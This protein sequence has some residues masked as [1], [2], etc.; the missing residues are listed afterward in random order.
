[1]HT[2]SIEGYWLAATA[3]MTGT[4]WIPYIVNRMVERGIFKALWDPR[5]DTT[6]V[7]QWADRMMRAHKNAVENLC[8]FAPL[9]LLAIVAGKL[10]SMTAM[11][12]EVYFFARLAHFIVYSAG[13]PIVR[14]VFF[15]VGVACQAAFAFAIFS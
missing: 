9:V 15:L 13:L 7:A 5:G 1:M 14:V 2:V 10:T 3:V 4:F 12:A 6:A 11:A 8:V